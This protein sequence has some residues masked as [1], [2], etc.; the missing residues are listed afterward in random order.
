MSRL[1]KNAEAAGSQEQ[2]GNGRLNL[3]RAMADTSTDS[4]QPAGA[5]PIGGGGPFVGPYV[6][7][8]NSF[9]VAPLSQSVNAASTQDYTWTFTAQNSANVA[10]TTVTEP[11]GHLRR[12]WQVRDR[13]SSPPGPAAASLN[14]VNW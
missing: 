10:T 9:N 8:A 11:G 12:P 3:D 2:T 5:A 1:A 4:I 13:S 6:A 14:S 7:A